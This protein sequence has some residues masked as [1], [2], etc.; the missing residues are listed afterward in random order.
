MSFIEILV[1]V[2]LAAIVYWIAGALGL[3]FIVAAIA[4]ILVLLAGA[5]SGGSGWATASTDADGQGRRHDV[6]PPRPRCGAA[7]HPLPQSTYKLPL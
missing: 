5:G 7:G 4:A 3:P 2:L 1:T 6:R